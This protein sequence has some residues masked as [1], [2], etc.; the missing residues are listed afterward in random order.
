MD[1]EILKIASN[2]ENNKILNTYT[3]SSKL[4]NSLCGDEISLSVNIKN[5]KVI[6]VGYSC[7]S[8]I[9]CEASASLLAKLIKKKKIN[10]I[11]K[12]IFQATNF[13]RDNVQLF[14]SEWSLLNKIFNKK[15]TSRKECIILPFKALKKAL[16]II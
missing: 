4:K 2:D 16:K 8:C 13:F 11:N 9:Y 3:H 12:L 14:T 1:L 5:L 7:N 15:N 6:D 10:E